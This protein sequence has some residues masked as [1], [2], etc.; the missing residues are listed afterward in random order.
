MD[1]IFNINLDRVPVMTTDR[2]M[3]RKEQARLARELFKRLGIKGVSVTAPNYSMAHS[4]DVR[5]PSQIDPSE[6]VYN[7]TNYAGWP[8]SEMPDE[9]PAKV[10]AQSHWN[11]RKKIEAIL[12]RAF[13]N[14]DDRS[15]SQADYFDFKWSIS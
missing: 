8:F 11:A 9:V 14:H 6:F 13:P 5:V 3:P 12:A 4:V 10:R 2:H 15:D 1:A 7:G